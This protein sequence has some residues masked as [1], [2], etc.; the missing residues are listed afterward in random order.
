MT[1]LITLILVFLSSLAFLHLFLPAGLAGLVLTFCLC[2]WAE[3][4]FY[5]TP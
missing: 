5:R 3:E 2:G 1:R 4:G